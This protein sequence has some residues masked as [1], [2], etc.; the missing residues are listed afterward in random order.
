MLRIVGNIFCCILTSTF[1]VSCSSLKSEHFVGER[2]P[3]LDTQVTEVTLWEFD[4]KVFFVN[5]VDPS[6]LI[7]STMQW[8]KTK[9]EHEILKSKVV[10]TELKD[11]KG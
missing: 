10:L 3:M 6:T 11:K 7:A 9:K 8:N 2:A 4:D 5:V 1:L